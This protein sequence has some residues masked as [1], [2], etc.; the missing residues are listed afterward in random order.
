M[1]CEGTARAGSLTVSH[2]DS[3]GDARR[4]AASCGI[5]EQRF[6]YLILSYLLFY[7]QIQNVVGYLCGEDE[8]IWQAG[9]Y[10]G[11]ALFPFNCF[12]GFFLLV[13]LFVFL[14][15]D[16]DFLNALHV[17]CNNKCLQ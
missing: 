2:P 7:Y 9:L 1:G 5:L 13:C 3:R 15:P 10:T 14:K 6:I 8:D 17:S 12:W 16:S 4:S 11:E